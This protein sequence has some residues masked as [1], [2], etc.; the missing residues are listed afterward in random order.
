MSLK[1]AIIGTILEIS[2]IAR[3][4]RTLSTMFAAG[5]PLV[6]AME[7]VAGA[8][9]NALYEEA[10]LRMRD[11]VSTGTQLQQSMRATAI[12][13]NMVVQMVAI[14]EESGSLDEMLSKIADF[15]EAEVDDLVDGLSSLLE[16]L[17]MAVL[18]VMVGGLV[19]AMYLPIFKLG[20]V[21]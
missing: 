1:V 5:V 12:F 6:E 9:G 7:S 8:T 15:Y 21:V 16:P 18:G 19:I 17:I 2:A 10:T 13:P 3:F 20:A 4:A 14:G 11:E